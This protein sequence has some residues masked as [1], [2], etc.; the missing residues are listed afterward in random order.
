MATKKTEP[1]PKA[2]KLPAPAPS[3]PKMVTLK[4][5]SCVVTVPEAT[6]PSYEKQDFKRVD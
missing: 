2:E 4:K 5:S 6:A 3:A 1:E